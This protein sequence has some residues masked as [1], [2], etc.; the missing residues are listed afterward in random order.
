MSIEGPT[1][2]QLAEVLDLIHDIA[3]KAAAE[4]NIPPIVD[5][6]LD[7]IIELS[8][9]KFNVTDEKPKGS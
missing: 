1:V 7:K 2:E 8:R 5:A 6:S 3:A 4:E 9:Y